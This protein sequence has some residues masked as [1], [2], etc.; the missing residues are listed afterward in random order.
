MKVPGLWRRIEWGKW[1]G[2]HGKAWTAAD[3]KLDFQRFIINVLS[4]PAVIEDIQSELEYWSME[5]K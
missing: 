1:W 5:A 2:W 4:P 3:V